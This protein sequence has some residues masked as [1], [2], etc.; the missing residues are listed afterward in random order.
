MKE[1]LIK[2]KWTGNRKHTFTGGNFGEF[3]NGSIYINNALFFTLEQNPFKQ[4]TRDYPIDY[5]FPI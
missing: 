5:G 1:S 3:I 4:E 2:S